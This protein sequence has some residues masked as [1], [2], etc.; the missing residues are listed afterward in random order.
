MLWALQPAATERWSNLLG[1]SLVTEPW[2]GVLRGGGLPH[3]AAQ[4]VMQLWSQHSGHWY[5]GT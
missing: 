5:Q 3:T 2:Q 4:P 1:A